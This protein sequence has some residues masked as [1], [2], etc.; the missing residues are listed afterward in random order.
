[1]TDTLRKD[2]LSLLGKE[3]TFQVHQSPDSRLSG[4]WIKFMLE[5]GKTTKHVI[6]MESKRVEI[7]GVVKGCE[8][9][10]VTMEVTD[11]SVTHFNNRLTLDELMEVN[12]IY[13]ALS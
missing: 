12:S 2:L 1:M 5:P 9:Q 11:I 3:L 13:H 7:S 4:D 6:E 10:Q 8:G